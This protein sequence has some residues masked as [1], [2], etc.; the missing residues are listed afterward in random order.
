MQMSGRQQSWLKTEQWVNAD[1]V[2]RPHRS[3]KMKQTIVTKPEASNWR[4]FNAGNIL[5]SA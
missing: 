1:V 4:K 2:K 5:F 3:H